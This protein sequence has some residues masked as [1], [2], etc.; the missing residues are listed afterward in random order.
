MRPAVCGSFAFV[1]AIAASGVAAAQ[2]VSRSPEERIVRQAYAKLARYNQASRLEELGGSSDELARSVALKFRLSHFKAGPISQLLG[3]QHSE[4]VTP[5]SGEIIRATRTVTVLDNGEEQVSYRAAWTAASYRPV[6]DPR[7]SIAEIV[8]ANA[9]RYHDLSDYISYQ[10]TVSFEGK[11]RAYRAVAVFHDRYTEPGSRHPEFWDQIVGPGGT[12]VNVWGD[13]RPPYRV[14]RPSSIGRSALAKNSSQ[15]FFMSVTDENRRKHTGTTG[16]HG[17]FATPFGTCTDTPNNTQR[18]EFNEPIGTLFESGSVEGFWILFGPS[19]PGCFPA[20]CAVWSNYHEGDIDFM[21]TNG[22]GSRASAVR[23]R[24]GMGVSFSNCSSVFGC[25][26][27]PTV[28]FTAGVSAGITAGGKFDVAVSGGDLYNE[29]IGWELECPPQ[30]TADAGCDNCTTPGWDGTCPSGSVFNPSCAMCCFD[31]TGG[32]ITG[33]T[34]FTPIL[35]GGSDPCTSSP[36]VVD[37][38]GN[39]FDLTSLANGVSFDLNSD[40]ASEPLAWTVAGSDD[41]FLVLDRDGNGWIDDGRE[42]F[43]NFT[44]QPASPSANGFLA[45]AEFDKGEHG[46]NGDG[47]IDA[48][49]AVFPSLRLWKDENHNGV[50]EE[51]EIQTLPSLGVATFHLDYKVSRKT[52]EYGNAFR[53][54]A[55][56]DDVQHTGV[57]R[58]AWDVFFVTGQ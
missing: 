38:A 8:A 49:D 10:V 55:K 1:L 29:G 9:D 52:D 50:S 28:G 27:K 2:G 57:G 44:P 20:G 33:G 32:C 54:R 36:I 35:D 18:C 11:Q 43:G 26:T 31:G 12:L 58:W 47:V 4:M 56:V 30:T 41:A 48:R 21:R 3:N 14:E 39:G 16:T 53:Y 25:S 24:I 46:G 42:L 45:L 13:R 19:T 15:P 51:A 23:C 22:A 40:G 5:P 34:G 6:I 17:G 37:V 7:Q